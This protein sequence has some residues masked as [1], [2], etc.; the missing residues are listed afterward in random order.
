MILYEKEKRRKDIK[1][2]CTEILIDSISPDSSMALKKNL[3]K[4]S[5]TTQAIIFPRS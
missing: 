2:L 3:F 1:F 5:L 4:K